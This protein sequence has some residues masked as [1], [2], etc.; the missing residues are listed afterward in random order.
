MNNHG[1]YIDG[2]WIDGTDHRE[3]INPSDT[4]EVLGTFARASV[5]DRR[6]PGAGG[7]EARHDA[8][9]LA[10]HLEAAG[11]A[12]EGVLVDAADRPDARPQRGQERRVVEQPQQLGPQG[13]HTAGGEQESVLA[14]AHE[15]AVAAAVH[16]PQTLG[17]ED[18]GHSCRIASTGARRDAVREG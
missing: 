4:S 5:G 12:P 6:Q 1:L 13:G 3:N 9:R 8:G 10:P 2:A 15:A 11:H 14:M 16:L 7:E 17:L 18:E